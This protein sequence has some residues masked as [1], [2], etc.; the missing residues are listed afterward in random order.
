MSLRLL[1]HLDY[2]IES[3]TSFSAQFP[4][5]L[6]SHITD[7]TTDLNEA[8]RFFILITKEPD[9]CQVIWPI[10]LQQI[11]HRFDFKLKSEG[12]SQT[13]PLD[14]VFIEQ[15]I[16]TGIWSRLIAWIN[17]AFEAKVTLLEGGFYVFCRPNLFIVDQ[18]TVL[19]EAWIKK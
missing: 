10:Q 15:I 14:W 13:R 16:I 6:P 8:L 17:A 4:W 3:N 9:H 18:A 5:Q 11:L 12:E 1:R 7:H 19:A 2:H